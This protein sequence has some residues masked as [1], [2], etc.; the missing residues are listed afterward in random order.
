MKKI[1]WILGLIVS[2]SIS[3][4]ALPIDECKTDIY[5]GNG[6]W[7]TKPQAE[8]SRKELEIRIIKPEIIKDN[9]A[10]QA[11][12]GTVKLQYNW[13]EGYMQDVN[14]INIA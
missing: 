12:Y 5:Y 9:S 7:N 2:L 14:V 10:L 1:L 3:A 6:V 4:F 8:I 13:G 11:K